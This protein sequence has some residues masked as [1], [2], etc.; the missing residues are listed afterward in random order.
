VLRRT[1]FLAVFVTAPLVAQGRLVG[2][3][4]STIGPVYEMWRFGNGGVEQP[5][6]DGAT[7]VR[8]TEASQWSLPIAVA[9]PIGERWL[10]DLTGAYASGVVTLAPQSSASGSTE[11]KLNGVTDLRLRVSGQL[12]GNATNGGVLLTLAVTAPTGKT[13]L[14]PDEVGALQVI[15]APALAFQVPTLGAGAGATAGLVGA[16]KL[17]AWSLALGL[18]Y[19]FRRLYEPGTATLGVPLPELNPSDALHMSLGVDGLVGGRHAMTVA[20]S[21]DVFTADHLR[22]PTPSGSTGAIGTTEV[23]TKLG[24]MVTLDWQLQVAPPP[25]FRE[26]TLYAVDRYRGAYS[27]SGETV[28]GSSG[29]YLDLGARGVL[30]AGS[31]T[32][33]L[34]WLSG[35]HQTGLDSD[36]TLATAAVRSAAFTLGLERQLGAGLTAQ[37]FARAQRGTIESGADR[38][39]LTGVAAGL[40]LSKAW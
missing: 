37:P 32:G 33:V 21:T 7:V 16:R 34:L 40:S 8:V 28:A 35:R 18:S 4:I 36:R 39:G 13:Q 30:R 38:S 2:T 17:G 19:E 31:K 5:T 29:N 25:A 26:I 9:V 20:L 15:A 12:A 14:N 27:R 3:R 11:Q 24:P 1:L 23:E 6:P 10:A 22:A